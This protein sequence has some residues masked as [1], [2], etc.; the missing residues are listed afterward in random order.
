MPK[1]QTAEERE[2]EKLYELAHNL[3]RAQLA[4]DKIPSPGHSAAEKYQVSAVAMALLAQA[5]VDVAQALFDE[6]VEQLVRRR[7][8]AHVQASYG[9][10]A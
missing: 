7:K 2:A 1:M 3:A 6:A 4:R 5:E 8:L 9:E 10:V